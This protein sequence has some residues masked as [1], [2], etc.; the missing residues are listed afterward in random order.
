MSNPII[1]SVNKETL[2]GIFN[3]LE[4]AAYKHRHQKRKG[5][6]GIPYINHPIE[7]ANFLIKYCKNPSSELIIAAILHD[8]LEDTTAKPQDLEIQFGSKVLKIVLELTDDMKLSSVKRKRLQVEK[9]QTLSLEARAIKIAD[10]SCNIDDIL[11][12]RIGW[13]INRKIS[14]VQWAI[15]VISQIGDSHPELY[16]EFNAIV[17]KAEEILKTDFSNSNRTN[18]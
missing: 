12:T 15:E 4:Y 13:A 5:A 3:A 6:F 10:K 11:T 7:V 16:V 8:T 17:M 2:P 18:S 1:N 9:A 14:Y